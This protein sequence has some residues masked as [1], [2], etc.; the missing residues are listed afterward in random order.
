M[1]RSKHHAHGLRLLPQTRSPLGNTRGQNAVK[2]PVGLEVYED[3]RNRSQNQPVI[4]H[5]MI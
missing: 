2:S 4:P 5:D 1:E 3:S